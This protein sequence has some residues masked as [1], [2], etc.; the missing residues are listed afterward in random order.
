MALKQP[1]TGGIVV[2]QS[3]SMASRLA[4]EDTSQRGATTWTPRLVSS[5]SVSAA[6]CEDGPEREGTIK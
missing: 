6:A 2:A 1:L 5:A 4:D 3:F